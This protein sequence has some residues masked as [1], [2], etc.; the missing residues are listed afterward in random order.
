MINNL[1]T[2]MTLHADL[3]RKQRANL[4]EMF[5]LALADVDAAI[6]DADAVIGASP[7]PE[8]DRETMLGE[9]SKQYQQAA[10]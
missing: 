7:E 2:A 9:P 5:Q 4:A 6:A 10:E 3:L 1:N 8:Q